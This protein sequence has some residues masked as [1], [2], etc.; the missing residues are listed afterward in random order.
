MEANLPLSD[1]TTT[2]NSLILNT[3]QLDELTNQLKILSIDDLSINKILEKLKPIKTEPHAFDEI[4]TVIKNNG[5]FRIVLNQMVEPFSPNFG[6]YLTSHKFVTIKEKL[7]KAIEGNNKLIKINKK[8]LVYATGE[9]K[10]CI[11]NEKNRLYEQKMQLFYMHHQLIN[12]NQ[13][14]M[15]EL[16]NEIKVFFYSQNNYK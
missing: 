6:P 15:I 9:L 13:T 12:K 16:H 1:D 5:L 14:E 11:L 7:L 8:L 2:Q 10:N 4:Q 3:N